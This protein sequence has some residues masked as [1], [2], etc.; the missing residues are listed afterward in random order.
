[1]CR[2]TLSTVGINVLGINMLGIWYQCVGASWQN[3]NWIVPWSAT[4]KCKFTPAF[5]RAFLTNLDCLFWK[6]YAQRHTCVHGAMKIAMK[7][8]LFHPVWMQL[9]GFTTR[10]NFSAGSIITKRMSQS[11][12]SIHRVVCPGCTKNACKSPRVGPAYAVICME[13]FLDSGVY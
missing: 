11:A 4:L 8:I 5:L 12:V 1:M 13:R 6:S 3:Q 7:T 10:S 9:K 2:N